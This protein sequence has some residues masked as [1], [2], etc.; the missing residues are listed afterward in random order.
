MGISETY[1][2][3]PT[4]IIIRPTPFIKVSKSPPEKKLKIYKG[5]F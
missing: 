2:Y 5:S 1:W 4:I 3:S